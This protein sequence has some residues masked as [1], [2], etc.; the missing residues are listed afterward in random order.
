MFTITE[1]VNFWLRSL[2]APLTLTLSGNHNETLM[3][4]VMSF[5]PTQ[6]SHVHQGLQRLLENKLFVKT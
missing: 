5:G 3:Y 1:E 4:L 6:L 2:T